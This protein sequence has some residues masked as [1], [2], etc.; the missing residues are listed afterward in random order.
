MIGCIELDNLVPEVFASLPE[1]EWRGGVW[2]TDIA[3]ERGKIYMIRAESGRGKSS[4]CSF[5]CGDRTDYNGRI[6]F[7]GNDISAF[8]ADNWCSLRRDTLAWLPQELWL[9]PDL[10]VIDNIRVKNDMTRYKSEEWIKQALER[11]ELFDRV[12]WPAG[13][14]SVGQQQRVAIIRMLCQ[15]YSFMLLDE[16][17]SHLD[18]RRASAAAAMIMEE[19]R[20]QGAGVIATSVGVDIQLDE[21]VSIAL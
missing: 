17:V 18:H 7:D 15:P 8:S 21:A 10:T 13:K 2:G 20:S 16:P 19:V 1:S 4:L 11:M 6:L 5:I 12:N 3:F 9:F 14:I